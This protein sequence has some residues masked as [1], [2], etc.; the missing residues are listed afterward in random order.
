[1]EL[2]MSRLFFDAPKNNQ[3]FIHYKPL[4]MIGAKT[5]VFSYFRARAEVVLAGNCV[6]KTKVEPVPFVICYKYIEKNKWDF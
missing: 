1:M 5:M 6:L 3:G 2:V 4:K